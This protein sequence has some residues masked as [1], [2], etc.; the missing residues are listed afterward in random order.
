MNFRNQI[1]L[2]CLQ[3][4]ISFLLLR[5]FIGGIKL[6]Q[7]NRSAYKKRKKGETLKEWFFYSRYR[8]EIP[9]IIIWFYLGVIVIHCICL[10]IC[11]AL[12]FTNHSYAV[13]RII[14]LVIYWFDAFWIILFIILFNRPSSRDWAYDRWIT[15]RR[16]KGK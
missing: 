13:G 3:L 16:G 11:T 15:K 5:Q 2:I 10:I 1:I 4:L 6:Y 14:A 12:Y 8:E 9:K 7:L